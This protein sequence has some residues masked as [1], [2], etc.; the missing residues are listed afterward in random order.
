MVA[1]G[2][3]LVLMSWHIVRFVAGGCT[4][5]TR[6]RFNGEQEWD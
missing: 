6:D 1:F 2:A 4:Q 5:K 3:L